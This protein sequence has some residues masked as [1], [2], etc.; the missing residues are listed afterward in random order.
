MGSVYWLRKPL[1]ESVLQPLTHSQIRRYKGLH[2]FQRFRTTFYQT[3]TSLI[4]EFGE[5]LVVTDDCDCTDSASLTSLKE[6]IQERW[7]GLNFVIANIRRWSKC[8]GSTVRWY[9]VKKTW[10]DNFKSALHT[11]CTFLPMLRE[12]KGC[13]LLFHQ[14]QRWKHSAHRLITQLPKWKLQH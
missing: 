4:A 7:N 14:S 9:S 8:A 10:D 11:A 5:Y 12:S 6:R 13:L 1:Q 3:K 2:C